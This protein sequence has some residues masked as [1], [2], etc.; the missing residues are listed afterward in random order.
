MNLNVSQNIF[1]N[2]KKKKKKN[3]NENEKHRENILPV[4]V[5]THLTF[6]IFGMELINII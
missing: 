3:E 4:A 6:S 2:E 5:K 1:K